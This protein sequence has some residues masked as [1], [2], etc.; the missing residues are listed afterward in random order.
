MEIWMTQE[1][2]LLMV[3]PSRNGDFLLDTTMVMKRTA[4]WQM[5]ETKELPSRV[6]RRTSVERIVY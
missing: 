2:G 3:F 4:G 6:I 1:R 5:P